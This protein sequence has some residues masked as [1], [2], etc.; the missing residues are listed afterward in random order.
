MPPAAAAEPAIAAA[1][2]DSRNRWRDLALLAADLVFET[3]E[4]GRL[5]FLAPDPVLGHARDALLGRPGA[6]LLA[7]PDQPDPFDADRPPRGLRAWLRPAEGPPVCLEFTAMRLQGGLRGVARDVTRAERQDAAAARALRRATALG[8]LLGNAQRGRASG[9]AEAAL[10]A[11]LAGLGPTLGAEG[12]A[13]LAPDGAAWRVAAAFGAAALPLL[14]G[15]PPP[16]E[17][18][19]EPGRVA[20]VPAGGFALLAW[21]EA[22]F[23]GDDLGLM[24]ALAAP[25]AALQAEAERQR[26]L[27][28]AANSDG[29]TG[30]LNRRGLIEALVRRLAAGETGVLAY[31]DLDGLKPLNDQFG[32]EAGD[33]AL[34]LVGARLRALAGPRDL[35]ARL[36]GDEFALWLDGLDEAEAASRCAGLGAPTPLPG[37]PAAGPLAVAA[38]LGLA[39]SLPGD[40][41]D[42]VLARADREMYRAKPRRRAPR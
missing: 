10:E 21:R 39:P 24:A 25:L 28:E 30:L 36:G 12:A 18:T 34:R 1:L 32:H 42:A 3:D 16:G 22:P 29:L 7:G 9:A 4:D 33:A 41:V 8:H 38:S 15:L 19:P 35:A 31:L 5:A 6:A 17:A 20:L 11:L 13:L 23:D 40:S 2:L 37:F 27:G 14:D 26:A